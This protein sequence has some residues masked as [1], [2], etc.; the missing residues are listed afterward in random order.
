[1][2]RAPLISVVLSVVS[3]LHVSYVDAFYK[4][5]TGG[6]ATAFYY[7]TRCILLGQPTR[8]HVFRVCYQV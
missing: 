4:N 3:V 5:T 8:T 1:M 2:L 6:I 7:A